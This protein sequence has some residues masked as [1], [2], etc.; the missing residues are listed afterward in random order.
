MYEATEA[1]SSLSQE[2]RL[3]VFKLLI[4][5]GRD[6]AIPGALAEELGI[7]ANTLSFHL[8]HMSK[9]GLVSSKKN[10]R[11]ITYFANTEL[12]EELIGYLRSNC[13]SREGKSKTR[14]KGCI[15][16]KC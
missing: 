8:S 15:E 1:F 14:A 7:P 2:T 16:R 10:G 3:R 9:A 4:E 12:I 13:C 11:S 5:Y 6:G